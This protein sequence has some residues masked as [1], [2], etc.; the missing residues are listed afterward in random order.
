[1]TLGGWDFLWGQDAVISVVALTHRDTA[2]LS[3]SPV[4]C[5]QT[6]RVIYSYPSLFD[7]TQRDP[8]ITV[9][10]SN[11]R[12]Q[13]SITLTQHFGGGVS[14]FL[15]FCFLLF[16]PSVIWVT[17]L[18][19]IIQGKTI[20]LSLYSVD[21]NVLEETKSL[22]REQIIRSISWAL[23]SALTAWRPEKPIQFA[24][25]RVAEVLS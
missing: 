19:R 7:R 1:M 11:A 18:P 6:A 2:L 21:Y 15:L 5:F 23:W 25:L 9:P 4:V 13:R 12:T 20:V 8:F 16:S 10:S 14:L 3:T 17:N 24:L 22:P